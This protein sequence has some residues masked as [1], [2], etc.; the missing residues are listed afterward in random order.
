MT[1]EAHGKSRSA[2]IDR[3]YRCSAGFQPAPI[4]EAGRDACATGFA[5]RKALLKEPVEADP[6]HRNEII[7]RRCDVF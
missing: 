6:V 4:P 2:V 1:A 3:R 5:Q 7:A